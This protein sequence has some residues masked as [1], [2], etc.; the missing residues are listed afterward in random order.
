MSRLCFMS[1]PPVIGTPEKPPYP[2]ALSDYVIQHRNLAGLSVKGLAMRCGFSNLTKSIDILTRF[3]NEGRDLPKDYVD[4]LVEICGL[5]RARYNEL[6]QKRIDDKEE[7]YQLLQKNRYQRLLAYLKYTNLILT[8]P[9]FFFMLDEAIYYRH[10]IMPPPLT[11]GELVTHWK[12]GIY[13][14]DKS[15]CGTVYQLNVG[16]LLFTKANGWYGFCVN[17]GKPVAGSGTREEWDIKSAAR[18]KFRP[19]FKLPERVCTTDEFMAYVKTL[20]RG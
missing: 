5:D 14:N 20:E 17:C 1:P 9:E 3:E 8:R 10:F 19:P 4:K 13:L 15:C 18:H 11:V 2:D 7:R 16:G 12:R 6:V